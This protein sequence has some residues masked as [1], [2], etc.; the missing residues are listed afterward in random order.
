MLSSKDIS[1]VYKILDKSKKK[2]RSSG[3]W[4]L[5]YKKWSER[6]KKVITEVLILRR[7]HFMVYRLSTS[8]P[9]HPLTPINIDFTAT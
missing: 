8:H 9:S 3:F 4:E 7:K 2:Q 6:T 1:K 5:F